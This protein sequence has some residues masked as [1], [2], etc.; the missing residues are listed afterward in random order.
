MPLL[1]HCQPGRHGVRGVNARRLVH[2]GMLARPWVR[3][4]TLP[5][6]AGATARAVCCSMSACCAVL[7]AVLAVDISD[8]MRA[9]LERFKQN[10]PVAK[11]GPQA[12][13]CF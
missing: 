6:G 3:C 12:P 7:T 11:E 5:D 10:K 8:T 13:V 9:D 4:S 2:G 1:A